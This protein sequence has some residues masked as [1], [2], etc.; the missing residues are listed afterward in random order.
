MR[1]KSKVIICDDDRNI[2]DVL[3]IILDSDTVDVQVEYHSSKL[4]NRI[5]TERPD[6]LIVDLWM[7]E[8]RGDEIIRHLRSRR[9]YDNLNILSISASIEGGSISKMAGANAFLSKPFNIEEVIRVVNNF[10]KV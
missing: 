3:K 4:L 7:P 1:E 6:V 2:A 10:I 5:E 9:E 8:I